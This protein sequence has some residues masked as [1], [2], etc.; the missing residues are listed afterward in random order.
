VEKRQKALLGVVIVLGLVA[1]VDVA[2]RDSGEPEPAGEVGGQSAAASQNKPKPTPEPASLQEFIDA[3]NKAGE[4]ISERDAKLKKLSFDLQE[5]DMEAK[6]A[7]NRL[8]K[9]KARLD[10]E[11]QEAEISRIKA[12][13]ERLR[14]L[15]RMSEEVRSRG[16]ASDRAP[17]AQSQTRFDPMASLLSIPAE[18]VTRQSSLTDITVNLVESGTAVV[19][20][21][22][23]M[24]RVSTGDV[25]AGHVVAV[26]SEQEGSITLKAPS[27]KTHKRHLDLLASRQLPNIKPLTTDDNTGSGTVP[28]EPAPPGG[29]S[30]FMGGE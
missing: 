11:Q 9:E 27:G 19:T 7:Q 15:D 22:G 28:P 13:A 21:A 25:V 2:M 4:V 5:S 29:L 18:P 23:R 20:V 3:T 17:P 1:A 6:I 12:E 8:V 16:D 14:Q 30:D 10:L 24:Q 26:I